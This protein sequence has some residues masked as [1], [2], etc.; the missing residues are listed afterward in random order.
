MSKVWKDLLIVL[1]ILVLGWYAILKL[2]PSDYNGVEI[3]SLENE[4]ELG[5]VIVDNMFVDNPSVEI[6][7]DDSVSVVIDQ[8]SSRLLN[9]LDSSSYD[10]KFRVINDPQV[11]A[12]TIPGGN[13]FIYSGLIKH[14][15]T[16]EELA[17]VLAHEIGHAENRHVVSRLGKE[18]GL[19][20]LFTA[21][22]GGNG[23]VFQAIY[24][25][26]VSTY[27]DREQEIESDDFAFDLLVKSKIDPIALSN[28]FSRLSK[29][30]PEFLKHLEVLNTHPNSE[31]RKSR[32]VNK[33][34]EIQSFDLEPFPSLDWQAFQGY[35]GS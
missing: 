19:T 29:K 32:V 8:I 6:I 24:K 22:S 1:G 10:Y 20:V 27:F 13:I 25:Q 5:E 35:I 33:R 2:L 12:F 15:E 30:E 3:L 26:I 16:P 18:L 21:V 4:L 11:N 31:E 7:E 17:A 34:I 9:S 14:A 28:F 23:E